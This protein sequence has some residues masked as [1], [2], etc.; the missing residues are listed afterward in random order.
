MKELIYNAK[1]FVQSSVHHTV[2]FLILPVPCVI[3]NSGIFHNYSLLICHTACSKQCSKSVNYFC[4][5]IFKQ[6]LYKNVFPQLSPTTSDKTLTINNAQSH[7]ERTFSTFYWYRNRCRNKR[8]WHGWEWKLGIWFGS[9]I[10]I[11]LGVSAP[12]CSPSHWSQVGMK[13][14]TRLPKKKEVIQVALPDLDVFL[15]HK[16]I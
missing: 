16:K 14:P 4:W 5:R 13:L 9:F 12:W 6:N 8:L 1:I 2:Q 3:W 10:L 11:K 7:E 15:Y